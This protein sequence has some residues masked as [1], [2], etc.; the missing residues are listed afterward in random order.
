MSIST[1][2]I[3]SIALLSFLVC[4][5]TGVVIGLKVRPNYLG[6]LMSEVKNV[7]YL[8]ASEVDVELLA[9]IE[10]GMEESEEFATIA[11]NL[12]KYLVSDRMEYAYIIG[13]NEDGSL[14]FVVDADEEEPAAIG[15]ECE[16]YADLVKAF[17]EG[18]VTSDQEITTDEWG[19]FISGYAP[20]I[21]E[22]KVV[23]VVGIDYDANEVSGYMKD[24]Y[25]IVAISVVC[26]III[27]VLGTWIVVRSITR[28]IKRIV[29]KIDDVVHNEGD[30]NQ[31]IEMKS[32]DETEVI[33]DLFNEFIGAVRDV[34][35]ELNVNSGNVK[36]SS[37][38]VVDN[39][40]EVEGNMNDIADK[41]HSAAEKMEEVTSSVD[42]IRNSIISVDEISERMV[43][44][45][46]GGME[47]SAEIRARATGMKEL[48]ANMKE[49]SDIIAKRIT[50]VLNEKIEESQA[51]KEIEELSRN[52]IDISGHSNLLAL[53]ASIEAAR[54]GEAGKGF[55]VVAGEIAKMA[56]DTKG[57]AERIAVISDIAM[58]AVL[59]LADAAKELADYV[60]GTV[61]SDYQT[62]EENGAVYLVDADRINDI[63]NEFEIV[64]NS[65]RDNMNA[66]KRAI[67][68][69]ENNMNSTTGELENV[70]EL[71]DDMRNG[72]RYIYDISVE[73]DSA[74]EELEGS[75]KRFKC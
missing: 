24:L 74:M 46:G 9:K 29:T 8:A 6:Q 45:A 50:E 3:M 36:K 67:G 51:V 40:R 57:A 28:N 61:S 55:A 37:A 5:I 65:L 43:E 7:S 33:A 18:V 41:L 59:G 35:S 60:N 52:I 49:Q 47:F 22:D 10:P 39:V 17:E 30:L 19:S 64:A 75:A 16:P 27:S 66:I 58:T 12:R 70:T 2:L 38:V 56:A 14:Y 21:S 42:S 11:T 25:I 48:S 53:N 73:N 68:D 44:K 1:K 63:M 69:V 15:E 13:R 26:G 34:V 71:S 72:I 4:A 62:F 23:G 20:I 54:A 31:T 32:G